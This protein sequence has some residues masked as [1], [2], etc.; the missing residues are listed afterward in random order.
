MGEIAAKY[1]CPLL[2]GDTVATPG[3]LTLSITA[4]G[5]VTAGR[6]P[7]RTTAEPGDTFYVSGTDRRRRARPRPAPG[8]TGPGAD[9]GMGGAALAGPARLPASIA[10]CVRA[11]VWRWFRR[12]R[13]ASAAMD[14]SDGLVGDLRALSRASGVSPQADLTKVPLSQPVRLALEAKPE[15]F[16]LIMCGGDDYEILCAVTP[17]AVE[18]FEALAQAAA[19]EVAAFGVADALAT[20]EFFAGP[21]GNRNKIRARSL[22]SFLVLLEF[23]VYAAICPN[24]AQK[25]PTF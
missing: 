21:D 1:H 24:V 18:R 9:A 20:P 14:V 3:P 8:R 12:S 16:E 19:V 25:A 22:Q 13:A 6:M 2:G 17:Q 5:A 7:R 4:V 15:L 23:D 10:I 11:R